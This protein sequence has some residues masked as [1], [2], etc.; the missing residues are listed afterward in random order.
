MLYQG[1]LLT[2]SPVLVA[3]WLRWETGTSTLPVCP[4]GDSL[5]LHLSP[6]DF[7]LP[8]FLLAI[9][10]YLLHLPTSTVKPCS[11]PLFQQYT[12]HCCGVTW[13]AVLCSSVIFNLNFQSVKEKRRESSTGRQ[14][15]RELGASVGDSRTK[16][17][18]GR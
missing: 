8:P 11:I 12:P 10:P 3:P 6:P 17:R 5:P 7:T 18:K 13:A 16:H 2:L 9:C 15:R 1:P 4:P 14:R